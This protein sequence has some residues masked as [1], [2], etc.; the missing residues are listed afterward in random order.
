ML[1]FSVAFY[2]NCLVVQLYG[3]LMALPIVQACFRHSY[4]SVFL[5]SAPGGK[6]TVVGR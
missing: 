2:D 4:F 6:D 1:P 5:L 3:P